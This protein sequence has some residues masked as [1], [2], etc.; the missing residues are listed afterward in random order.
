[1]YWAAEVDYEFIK[2]T[3]TDDHSCN[4][5]A[6]DWQIWVHCE[7]VKCNSFKSVNAMIVELMQQ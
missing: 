1:M 3:I 5:M 7:T 6:W 2:M 4:E